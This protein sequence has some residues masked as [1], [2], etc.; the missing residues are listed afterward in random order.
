MSPALLKL[1][2][3]FPKKLSD[4]TM[5]DFATIKSVLRLDHINLTDDLKSAGLALLQGK[6][7]DTVADLVQSPEAVAQLMNFFR[8]PDSVR[9]QQQQQDS[10]VWQCRHCGQFS[11]INI[12]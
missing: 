2:P 6:S 12:S 10:L 3:L 7:I 4:L 8:N 11:L 9:Q 5:E 1:V